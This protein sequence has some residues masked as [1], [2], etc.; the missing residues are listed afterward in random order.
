MASD[1]SPKGRN[2]DRPVV[3]SNNLV[4]AT[5][6]DA[7]EGTLVTL[8]NWTNGPVK[9]LN[10]KVRVPFRP[11]AV[12]SVSGQRELKAEYADGVASFTLDLAEADYVILRK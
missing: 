11:S 10:V 4:E 6:L 1:F 3:C 8:V 12:R 2:V 5:V 7:K 9:D